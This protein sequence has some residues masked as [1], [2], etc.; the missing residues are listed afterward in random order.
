MRVFR[1]VLLF[2][3]KIFCAKIISVLTNLEPVDGAAVDQRREHS[4][5]RSEGI[6]NGA[7]RQDNV[8]VGLDP[9]D[10]VVVHGNVKILLIS[11]KLNVSLFEVI[12]I[13]LYKLN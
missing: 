4:Q 5:S 7:H 2:I 6:P 9:L 11:L 8:Q 3:K 12:A 13:S 1:L 10:E